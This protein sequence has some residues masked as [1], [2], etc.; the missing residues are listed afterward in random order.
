MEN[1]VN[2]RKDLLV[3]YLN[4]LVKYDSLEEFQRL[5]PDMESYLVEQVEKSTD[6]ITLS[7][8]NS[9][10]AYRKKTMEIHL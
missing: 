5:Y 6:T 3:E 10:L 2:F 9:I 7:K 8:I 4:Q 1:N